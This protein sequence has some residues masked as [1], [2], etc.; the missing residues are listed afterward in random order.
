MLGQSW[1]QESGVAA[2]GHV[3]NGS[4]TEGFRLLFGSLGITDGIFTT[5]AIRKGVNKLEALAEGCR[6]AE[7][8]SALSVGGVHVLDGSLVGAGLAQ[9]VRVGELRHG[10]SDLQKKSIFLLSDILYYKE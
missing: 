8:T 7:G 10:G 6:S 9:H 1:L 3:G 5:L 2:L 4:V